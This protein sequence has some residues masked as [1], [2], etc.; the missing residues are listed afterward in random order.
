MNRRSFL[1]ASLGAAVSVRASTRRIDRSRVSAI[2]DEVSQSPAEAIDF[3]HQPFF[4]TAFT[5]PCTEHFRSTFQ[6]VVGNTR[7]AYDT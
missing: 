1:A 5:F 7:T 6:G 3:A 2:S 4:H